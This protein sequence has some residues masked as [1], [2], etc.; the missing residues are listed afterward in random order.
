LEV[1]ETVWIV[2]PEYRTPLGEFVI[3]KAHPNNYFELAR[4]AD[5][6]PHPELVEEVHLTRDP[7]VPRE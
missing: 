1:G 3:T 7:F 2:M 5:R 6:V 4:K